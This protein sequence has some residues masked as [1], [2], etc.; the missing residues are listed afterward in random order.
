MTEGHPAPPAAAP[1]PPE[2]LRMFQESDRR[3]G[4]VIVL[5]MTAI[6]TTGLLMYSY[7]ALTD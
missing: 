7:I 3:T 4:G 6:F 1:F 5:L 2:E